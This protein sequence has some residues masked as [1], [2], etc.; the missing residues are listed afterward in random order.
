MGGIKVFLFEIRRSFFPIIAVI[1]CF[2]RGDRALGHVASQILQHRIDLLTQTVIDQLAR[3][4]DRQ[5]IKQAI[6][7]SSHGAYRPEA[8]PCRHIHKSDGKDIIFFRQAGDI[9]VFFGSDGMF[10]RNRSRRNDF[11]DFPLD[12]AFGQLRVFH[13]FANGYLVSLMDQP[14]NIGISRM[15]R[16]TTH[17]HPFFITASPTCQSQIQF[18]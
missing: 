3:F 9:I 4:I 12:D 6:F 10:Q 16:N 8:F 18:P 15:E 7:H 1:I 14:F 13:L 11:N 5:N 2:K 17:G